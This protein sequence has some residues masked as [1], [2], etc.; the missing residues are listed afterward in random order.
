M[1]KA[2][3]MTTSTTQHIFVSQINCTS[4]YIEMDVSSTRFD[5]TF[6]KEL[7]AITDEMQMMS[8][9]DR[10]GT[11]YM[12]SAYMGGKLV[13]ITTT[14]E[15]ISSQEKESEWSVAASLTLGGSVNWPGFHAKSTLTLSGGYSTSSSSSSSMESKSSTSNIMVYG[16]APAAFGPA[17]SATTYHGWT[18]SI[19]LLPVPLDFKVAPLRELIPSQWTIKLDQKDVPIKDIWNRMEALYYEMNGIQDVYY[20]GDFKY[21]L[22]M[23]LD[24][25]T[26]S[27][28]PKQS[29]TIDWIDQAGKDQ[30][31]STLIRYLHVDTDGSEREFS[32]PSTNNKYPFGDNCQQSPSDPI[33][34][35]VFW[36]KACIRG[37]QAMPTMIV[38]DFN[39]PDFMG[40]KTPPNISVA[41]VPGLTSGALVS[42]T[43]GE[44]L[45]IGADGHLNTLAANSVATFIQYERAI[46]G[47]NSA[48]FRRIPNCPDLCIQTR[49]GEF[50]FLTPAT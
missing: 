21:T 16:G 27:F 40:S 49:L 13:Q 10:F 23:N 15:S 7:A 17:S 42:W 46:Y 3:T 35:M 39:G 28:T 31:F 12:T 26:S 18:P 14:S 29:I 41:G 45:L 6:L 22:V 1:A 25:T 34:P 11:Y 24:P 9:F 44:G 37:S 43:T 5:P 2:S 33:P 48:P 47:N 32:F 19:D 20:T 38:F 8:I 4:T 36:G 30:T 50:K